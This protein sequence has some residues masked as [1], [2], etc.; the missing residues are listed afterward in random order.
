LANKNYGMMNKTQKD[1]KTMVSI[2]SNARSVYV[3][4]PIIDKNNNVVEIELEPVVAWKV[5]YDEDKNSSDDY[6]EPV[7]SGF[8][9]REYALYDH[10]TDIWNVS[11]SA[12]GNGLKNL[13]KHFQELSEKTQR[14][15]EQ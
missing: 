11:Q 14:R 15:Q 9:P 7:I 10:K 12:F 1:T 8:V 5:I 3:A 6:A 4:T 13:I 2:V